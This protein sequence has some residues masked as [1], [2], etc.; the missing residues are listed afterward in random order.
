MEHKTVGAFGP[1][2]VGISEKEMFQL[3]RFSK[4]R[5]FLPGF[6]MQPETL[7]FNRAGAEMHK[8]GE[9]FT[10]SWTDLGLPGAPTL[11]DIRTAVATMVCQSYQ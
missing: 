6:Y 2:M 11:R 1:A 7:F 3:L 10:R 4:L 8:L 5:N 9:Y